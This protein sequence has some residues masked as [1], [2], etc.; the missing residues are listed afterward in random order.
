MTSQGPS[1]DLPAR[2]QEGEDGR[3]H[4][5]PRPRIHL[6]PPYQLRD[7]P[8]SSDEKKFNGIP[9]QRSSPIPLFPLLAFPRY[10]AG[11]R[12]RTFLVGAR[13]GSGSYRYFDYVKL[14][15]QGKNIFKIEVLHIFR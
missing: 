5:W 14:Y 11:F 9:F 1:A 8:T 10:E 6:S 4:G 13:S 15:K 12:V 7:V 3:G 2:G